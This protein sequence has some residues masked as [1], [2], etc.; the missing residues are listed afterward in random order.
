MRDCYTQL[1]QH[2]FRTI[3]ETIACSTIGERLETFSCTTSELIHRYYL[4]R[5]RQQDQ[6]EEPENGQLTVRCWFQPDGLQIK[7]LRAEQLRLPKDYK[8]SCDSYVKL[9]VL[10]PDQFGAPLPELKTK[11]KSKNFSPIYNESFTL[12]VSGVDPSL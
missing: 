3:S 5:V 7:V 10:P 1:S 8:H 2:Y 9:N 11:T 4:E 6:L 12:Y